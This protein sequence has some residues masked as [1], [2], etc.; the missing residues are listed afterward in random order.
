MTLYSF[1]GQ[2]KLRGKFSKFDWPPFGNVNFLGAPLGKERAR[3]SNKLGTFCAEWVFRMSKITHFHFSIP[4][5]WTVMNLNLKV[6]SPILRTYCKNAANSTQ[7]YFLI[8]PMLSFFVTFATKH[9]VVA[10]GRRSWPYS[11]GQGLRKRLIEERVHPNCHGNN[12]TQGVYFKSQRME[13]EEGKK[14][15]EEWLGYGGGEGVED[16]GLRDG[17]GE[18]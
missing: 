7:N 5:Q 10:T 9:F 2:N 17:G 11:D 1:N 14:E 18:E 3:G 15:G 8:G 16:G 12:V 6:D 4:F 13:M